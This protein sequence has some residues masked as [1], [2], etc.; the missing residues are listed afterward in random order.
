[1]GYV[2]VARWQAERLNLVIVGSKP[3]GVGEQTAARD[4][5]AMPKKGPSLG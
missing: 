3:Y 5:K 4:K 2:N 1:M